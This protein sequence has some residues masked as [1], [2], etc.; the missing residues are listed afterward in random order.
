MCVPSRVEGDDQQGESPG[1]AVLVG[2]ACPGYGHEAILIRLWGE[3]EVGGGPGAASQEGADCIPGGD[4]WRERWKGW[5]RGLLG[6]APADK[7]RVSFWGVLWLLLAGLLSP[8][9]PRSHTNHSKWMC[10][11]RRCQLMLGSGRFQAASIWRRL[12]QLPV[13]VSLHRGLI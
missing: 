13:F 5:I 10:S 4:R 6:K 9:H 3:Q 7:G 8:P 1:A 2:F 12:A 11:A